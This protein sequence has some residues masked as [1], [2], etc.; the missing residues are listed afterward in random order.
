MFR[1][2]RRSISGS[3]AATACRVCG[4][5][6]AAGDRKAALAVI[7]DSVV[8]ELIIHGAPEEC[9]EHIDRYHE[10]GVTT[11]AISIMGFGGID[12]LQAARDLSPAARG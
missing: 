2:T 10:N 11:S 3:A 12:T 9:R 1:Y 7:P 5:N 4:D 6:W 8:D